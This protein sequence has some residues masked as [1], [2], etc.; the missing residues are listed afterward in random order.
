MPRWAYTAGWVAIGLAFAVLEYL[1]VRDKR[2]KDT[3]SEHIWWLFGL[4]PVIWFMGAGGL[5]WM[6]RHFLFKKG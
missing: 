6:V 1:A 5:I 2:K 3:L 4:H